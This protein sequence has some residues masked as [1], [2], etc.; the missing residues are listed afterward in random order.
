MK[1]DQSHHSPSLF[2]QPKGTKKTIK[3]PKSEAVKYLNHWPYT[4][5]PK[6]FPAIVEPSNTDKL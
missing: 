5:K 2:N 3:Y 6:L 4:T 1:K